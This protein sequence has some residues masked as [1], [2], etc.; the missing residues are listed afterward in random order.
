M[1][2][3]NSVHTEKLDEEVEKERHNIS[4]PDLVLQYSGSSFMATLLYH[5]HCLDLEN[6]IKRV[7]KS[8]AKRQVTRGR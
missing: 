4:N 5:V 6:D 2:I 1:V 7:V 3:A 8:V